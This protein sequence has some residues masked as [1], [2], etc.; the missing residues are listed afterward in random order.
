MEKEKCLAHS[1]SDIAPTR[2][3]KNRKS[4][5]DI[6]MEPKVYHHNNCTVRIYR[7]ILS[8]E[9]RERRMEEIKKTLIDFYI[10]VEKNKRRDN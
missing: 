2:K 6:Y 9:E 5:Q 1:K 8:E 10:E 3:R 4:S 7:P